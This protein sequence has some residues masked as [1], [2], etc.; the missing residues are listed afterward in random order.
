MGISIYDPPLYGLNNACWLPGQT[1]LK[2]YVSISGV[3]CGTAWTP[4]QQSPANGTWRL[5][6]VN[7][8]LW[9]DSTSQFGAWFSPGPPDSLLWFYT[10]LGISLFFS[11]V[12]LP[13]IFAFDN[14]VV[15]PAAVYYGGTAK[16]FW[17]VPG[18]PES[19][20]DTADLLNIRT[21][22]GTFWHPEHSAPGKLIHRFARHE[23]GTRIL[24]RIDT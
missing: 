7:F 1:P 23:G 5:E 11:Y 19:G 22:R 16:I 18:S 24:I 2:I 4:D 17:A 12:T 3:K 13:C 8:N 20:K 15:D 14:D 6:Q 21:D 10:K 9:I